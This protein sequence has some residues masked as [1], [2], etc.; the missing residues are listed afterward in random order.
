MLRRVMGAFMRTESYIDD[1]WQLSPDPPQPRSLVTATQVCVV[2]ISGVD[3]LDAQLGVFPKKTVPDKLYDAL[4]GQP[5]PAG[6]D[7]PAA[8]DNSTVATQ[9]HTYAVLDAANVTNLPE[10]LERSGLVH[11]CLF[12]G[13]SFDELKNVAP[14]V[15]KLEQGE[16]F[17]RHLF[18][19][20]DSS[21]CIWDNR[22][23]IYLR[24]SQ[25]IDDV[26][27]HLRKFTRMR[28][29][30]G[31]WHFFRFWEE[32][33]AESYLTTAPPD[34]AAYFLTGIHSIIAHQVF[35][36]MS[37]LSMNSPYATDRRGVVLTETVLTDFRRV[38][39]ARFCRDVTDWLCGEYTAIDPSSSRLDLLLQETEL[40][41]SLDPT[42]DQKSAAHYLAACWLRGQRAMSVEVFER[43]T[44]R[45]E[46]RKYLKWLHD[47]AY[48][49][50]VSSISET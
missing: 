13:Q 35:G 48:A 42:C 32:G 12:K 14:W 2:S 18:T 16:R 17:T 1:P 11:R 26:W 43:L 19:R 45:S 28:D 24:S 31:R 47:E 4:F 25:S 29:E 49:N 7:A 27:R 10:L 8:G 23:G 3:P 50:H 46:K 15:V 44:K 6:E 39:R 5:T 34:A 37:V 41:H 20:A 9:L 36:D 40:L 30:R 33:I 22:P 38:K 21:W